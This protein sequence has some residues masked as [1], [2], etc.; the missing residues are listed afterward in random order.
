M[1]ENQLA[2]INYNLFQGRDV[3]AIKNKIGTYAIFF[4]FTSP[5]ILGWEMTFKYNSTYT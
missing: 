4:V 2:K 1:N 3:P 5:F